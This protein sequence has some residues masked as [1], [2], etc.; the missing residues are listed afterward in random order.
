MTNIKNNKEKYK[1]KRHKKAFYNSK[2][3]GGKYAEKT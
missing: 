1:T 2:I 3:Y